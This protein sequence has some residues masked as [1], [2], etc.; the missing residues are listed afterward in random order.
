VLQTLIVRMNASP[1]YILV[2]LSLFLACVCAHFDH[3]SISDDE[4]VQLVEAQEVCN[5]IIITS[6][7]NYD[8]SQ[9]WKS[10]WMSK[11]GVEPTEKQVGRFN[12]YWYL[13]LQVLK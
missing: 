4:Y 3:V 6:I 11:W 2:V 7:Y 1:V 13:D 8:Y 10:E 5:L 9:L 12:Y